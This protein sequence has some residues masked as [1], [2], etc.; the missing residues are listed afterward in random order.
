MRQYL[1]A[2][3][4]PRRF[5]LWLLAAFSLSAVVLAVT[6]LYGLV[7][8][9][10]GRSGREIGVRMALGATE[11]HVIGYVL[12][13]A[14]ALGLAGAG[15]GSAVVVATRPLWARLPGAEAF[16][17]VTA[18][19]LTALLVGVASAAAWPPAR[20]ASRIQPTLALKGE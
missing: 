16:D 1:E 20:R 9:T 4:G 13:Q 8:Y 5:L 12:R 15:L 14:A 3:L 7:S 18:A 19:L 11:R 10:V 6:G 17:P 2:S